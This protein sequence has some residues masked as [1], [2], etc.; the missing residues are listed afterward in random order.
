MIEFAAEVV[1]WFADAGNWTGS[2]GVLARTWEHVWYSLFFGVVAAAVALPIGLAV[3]HTGRGGLFVINLANVG[4]AV[5]TFGVILIV[6]MYFF[7]LPAVTTALV[8]L[9]V[10]PMLTNAYTGVRSVDPEV[11]DAAEGMGMTGWQLLWRVELPVALPL[12]MAGVRTS[13]VQ[14][15]ATVTL[16]AWG[17]L[18]GLGLIIRVGLSVGDFT[19]VFAAALLVA[20]LALVTELVLARLQRLVTAEGIAQREADVAAAKMQ[21]AP[22]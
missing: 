14:L 6:G 7:G 2:D 12:V 17:G 1:A 8:A 21:K 20:L 4:R 3:G 5:P 18:G 13:M 9:S 11:R 10:P 19:R 16:A 22:A 15:V